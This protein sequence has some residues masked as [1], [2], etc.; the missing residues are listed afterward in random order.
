MEVAA[1]LAAELA[2]AKRA[3]ERLLDPSGSVS[4]GSGGAEEP[5]F[6]AGEGVPWQAPIVHAVTAGTLTVDQADALPG[7]S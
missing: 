6:D 2:T 5:S 1:A 4:G 7:D 3:A